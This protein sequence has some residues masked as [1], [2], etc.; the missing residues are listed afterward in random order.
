MTIV[1]ACA[2]ADQST[3]EPLVQGLV[4]RGHTTEL[5]VGAEIDAPVI[6]A[7]DQHGRSGFFVLC[8]S[9]NLLRERIDGLR[10]VLRQGR[11]PFSRTLTLVLEEQT[12]E[13]QIERI[14]GLVTRVSPMLPPPPIERTGLMGRVPETNPDVP[15]KRVSR[16]DA[17]EDSLVQTMAKA[18]GLPLEDDQTIDFGDV[19]VIDRTQIAVSALERVDR[20]KIEVVRPPSPEPVDRTIVA[21]AMAVEPSSRPPSGVDRTMI[22][23]PAPVVDP[24]ASSSGAHASGSGTHASTSTV[25][26]VATGS[27][28]T[29]NWMPWVLGG[30]GGLVVIGLIALGGSA[31]QSREGREPAEQTVADASVPTRPAAAETKPTVPTF[32]PPPEDSKPA[33]KAELEPS[34]PDIKIDVELSGSTDSEGP[35]SNEASDEEPEVDADDDEPTLRPLAQPNGT[36]PSEDLEVEESPSIDDRPPVVRA[37]EAR[38]VRALDALLFVPSSVEDLDVDRAQAYCKTLTLAGIDG[39]RLPTA[40]E[41]RSLG[42][43][44]M[45]GRAHYWSDTPGDA[46]GDARIV[47]YGRRSSLDTFKA[48][49]TDAL[50]LCVRSR[51]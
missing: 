16:D 37:L 12:P 2:T 23:M 4:A 15:T 19:H 38:E 9:P 32:I 46:F 27:S 30:V 49:R 24:S 20:T 6:G 47:Y 48:T 34:E 18:D 1:V 33:L 41:L 36:P 14:E 45:L 11:V 40:G 13:I 3:V 39:W 10:S 44:E 8:R 50:T 22:A 17:E 26:D 28:R 51:N 31:M 35:E 25:A 29:P 5:V 42:E 21:S 7:T 43:A